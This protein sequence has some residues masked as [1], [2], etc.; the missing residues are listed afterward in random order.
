M[1]FFLF[2]VFLTYGLISICSK[3]VIPCLS[4][5]II[6]TFLKLGAFVP[7]RSTDL[8]SPRPYIISQQNPFPVCFSLYLNTTIIFSKLTESNYHCFLMEL[9][10]PDLHCWLLSYFQ[11]SLFFIFYCCSSTVVYISPHHSTPPYF[12]KKFSNLPVMI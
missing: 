8:L 7:K 10:L 12:L 1:D 11:N 5:G 9:F 6:P 4:L 3:I 2:Y